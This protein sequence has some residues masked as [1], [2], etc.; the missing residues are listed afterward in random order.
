MLSSLAM[1][2][3]FAHSRLACGE[4]GGVRDDRPS[5][6]ASWVAGCRGLGALLLPDEA[7]LIDDPYGVRFGGPAAAALARLAAVAPAAA[8]RGGRYLRPLARF[9]LYMQVRTRALDDAL[10]DFARGGGR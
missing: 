1:A 8:R 4:D 6:T 7:R 10:L 5:G 9:L 2:G 3:I